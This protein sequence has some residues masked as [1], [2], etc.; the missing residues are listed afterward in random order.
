MNAAIDEA[1]VR[2]CQAVWT[3]SYSF[4]APGFYEKCGFDRIAEI[5]G[6]PPGHSHIVLRRQLRDIHGAETP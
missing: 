2:G 4:Q 3:L 1:L 6:W 5:S